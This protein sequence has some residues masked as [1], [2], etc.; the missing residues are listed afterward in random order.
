M[1]PKIDPDTTPGVKLLRLFRK[2]LLDSRR[3]YQND[4][5]EELQCSP[6]TVIRL[7][8]E[9]EAVVGASLHTGLDNRRRWYQYVIN[10]GR[11]LGLDFEELRFLGICREMA[12]GILP[13][14]VLQRVDSSLRH[15]ALHMADPMHTSKDDP[16]HFHA[17]GRIDYTPHTDHIEQ[18]VNAARSQKV[19]LVAYKAPGREE[20]REHRLVPQ[21]MIA[22]N[23][24]LYVLGAL[25]DPNFTPT[26]RSCSMAVHRITEVTTTGKR[27]T[28]LLPEANAEGFGLPWHEPRMFHIRFSARVVEYVRERNW[29]DNQIMENTTDGGLV[30]T[31]TT[32]AEPELRA[33]VRSFGEDACMLPDKLR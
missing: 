2:L 19:C 23:N 21:R 33:W 5:A 28:G 3:H 15:L 20:P 6:Q 11:S 29:A 30:L 32:R 4:L 31:L 18:L 13:A 7:V 16:F 12:S 8:S 25:V 14:P 27:V 1:P 26:G 10:E 24:A 17:K 9:V 22:M